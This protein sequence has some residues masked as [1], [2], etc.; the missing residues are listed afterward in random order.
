MNAQVRVERE[1]RMTVITLDRQESLNAINAAMEGALAAAF[2]AFEADPDQWVA[3]LTGAG[4]CAFSSGVDLK[5]RIRS[6]A[7][8]RLATGFGGLTRRFERLKPI[9]AAVNGLALGGGFE[10]ALACDLIIASENATF[11]LPEPRV[12]MV[13]LA[14]GIQRLMG[15]I[16]PKRAM[17][18]LLT[19]RHV[20]AA[21]GLALGFV[22]AVVPEG[23]TLAAAKEWALRMLECS[24]MSLRA[25][26][27]IAGHAD[28]D[29]RAA[30][31]LSRNLPAV[32]ALMAS[33]DSAEGPR[34]FVERRKPVWKNC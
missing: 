15:E 1:G 28:E 19:G 22:N 24:P 30:M 5:Q 11:A 8:A 3:I 27:E 2:D 31:D 4:D 26:K 6:E 25:I 7:P 9:V 32:K 18:M 21:E 14:G 29:L 23:A 10:M 13:A 16:G 20:S 17:S 12:G 33:K 34:A